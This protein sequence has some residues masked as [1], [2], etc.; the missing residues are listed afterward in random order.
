MNE[1]KNVDKRSKVYREWKQWKA[2]FDSKQ[3]SKPSGLGDVVEKVTKATGIDKV[4]KFIAGD[5]CKCDER[6]K[7]LNRIF[8]FRKP[9]CLNEKEYEYLS[10]FFSVRRNNVTFEKRIRLYEIYNRVFGT[11]L[12]NTNCS[13]CISN[14]VKKLDAIFKTYK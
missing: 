11:N 8:N 6:K 14:I 5:D 2:N 1:P 12:E 10:D 3:Q 13:S 4:V 9:N 7:E